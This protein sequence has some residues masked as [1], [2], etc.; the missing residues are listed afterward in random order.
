[1]TTI[2]GFLSDRASVMDPAPWCG[3]YI[4]R[5]EWV[6]R[7]GGERGGGGR[8]KE[9]EREKETVGRGEK[10]GGGGIE[11]VRGREKGKEEG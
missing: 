2:S 10:R 3:R 4:Y 5:M 9:R 8:E 1:M 11:M 7:G 6:S